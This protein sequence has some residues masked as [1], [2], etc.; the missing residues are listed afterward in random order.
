M[1]IIARAACCERDTRVGRKLPK[2]RAVSPNPDYI[3]A[4]VP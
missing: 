3:H 1:H 4:A 2:R